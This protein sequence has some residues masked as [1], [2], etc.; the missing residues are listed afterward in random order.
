MDKLDQAIIDA[1]ILFN[2]LSSE[3]DQAVKE[4][5]KKEYKAA[6]KEIERIENSLIV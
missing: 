4:R 1:Y 6:L 2:Q 5:Q 3:T